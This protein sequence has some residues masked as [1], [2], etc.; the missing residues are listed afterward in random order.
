MQ[1]NED[2]S[3]ERPPSWPELTQAA[4]EEGVDEVTLLAQTSGV[5]LG[6]GG[7]GTGW[8]DGRAVIRGIA[9][10]LLLPAASP[11]QSR[12]QRQL[13]SYPRILQG[14]LQQASGR[15]REELLQL[16]QFGITSGKPNT[17]GLADNFKAGGAMMEHFNALMLDREDQRRL[18]FPVVRDSD[19]HVKVSSTREEALRRPSFL[20][21]APRPADLP[22]LLSKCHAGEAIVCG[23][24]GPLLFPSA[25][26]RGRKGRLAPR[27]F[28]DCLEGFDGELL[29]RSPGLTPLGGIGHL[30]ITN[31]MLTIEPDQ[32]AALAEHEPALLGHFLV[33]KASTPP[34][35][36]ADDEDDFN[37]RVQKAVVA[38]L[39]RRR[40]GDAD[41]RAMRDPG[42][43]KEFRRLRLGFLR[44]LENHMGN[45]STLACLPETLAWTIRTLHPDED[46]D[47]LVLSV[48]IPYAEILVKRHIAAIEEAQNAKTAET[49]AGKAR[50]LVQ[51]I[52]EGGP[53]KERDLKRKFSDQRNCVLQPAL[54]RLLSEG[55]LTKDEE[56]LVCLGPMAGSFASASP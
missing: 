23:A 47:A 46:V 19:Y 22:D 37:A 36:E 12:L 16:A 53:M 7:A 2:P 8:N 29:P 55:I 28:V 21:D 9:P 35:F 14:R 32:I 13:L 11:L 42:E 51:R 5:L 15:L 48:A 30:Q 38:V 34:S 40:G 33:L 31:A 20:L 56:G 17:A 18:G 6:L 41:V 24:A 27:S 50:A 1:T 54:R 49:E 44:R 3:S 39:D 52:S 43:A 25:R 10:S 26:Q 4:A 45:A